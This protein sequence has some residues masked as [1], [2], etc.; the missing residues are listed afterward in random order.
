MRTILLNSLLVSILLVAAG[1]SQAAESRWVKPLEA[2]KKPTTDAQITAY[3]KQRADQR[4]QQRA[5]QRKQIEATKKVDINSA[6]MDELKTLQGIGDAEAAQIIALRPFGSKAWLVTKDIIHPSI[7]GLIK[8]KIVAQHPY[9]DG[10]KN[11]A[12]YETNAK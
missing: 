12:L 9:K 3:R 2:S 4:A 10:A 8:N 11:A 6:S 5:E 7:Y 1:Q